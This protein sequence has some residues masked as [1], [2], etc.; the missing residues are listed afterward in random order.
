M[1]E[2]LG[3]RSRDGSCDLIDFG[4]QITMNLTADFAGIDRPARTAAETA[5]LLDIV[6]DLQRRRD[7]GAL[8][9]RQRRSARR[10]PRGTRRFDRKFLQP[11]IAVRKR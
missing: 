3:R 6:D 11:S 7:A 9:A 10:G 2:V 8:D 4:Y 5:S 1:A